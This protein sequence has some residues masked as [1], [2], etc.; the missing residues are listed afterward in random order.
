MELK[1]LHLITRDVP[2]VRGNN[3]LYVTLETGL[4]WDNIIVDISSIC[5]LRRLGRVRTILCIREFILDLFCE[6]SVLFW[7]RVELKLVVV[8]MIFVG[9][10]MRRLKRKGTPFTTVRTVL[11]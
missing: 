8:D 10:C 1:A 11:Q 6:H 7:V 3:A 5:R 9:H 2:F 4:R